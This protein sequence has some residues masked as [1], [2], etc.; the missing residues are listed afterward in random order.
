[1]DD[2]SMSGAK[3]RVWVQIHRLWHRWKQHENNDSAATIAFYALVSLIP[4]LYLGIAVAGVFLGDVVAHGEVEKQ[5]TEVMGPNTAGTITRI[6]G[7]AGA[8][9]RSNVGFLAVIVFALGFAGSH[10]LAKLRLSLNVI[11]GVDAHHPTRPLLGRLFARGLSALLILIFGGLLV[12]WTVIDGL[13]LHFAEAWDSHV[14][15]RWR[16]LQGYDTLSSVVLLV[17]AFALILKV[18]PRKRPLWRYVWPGAVFSGVLVSSLKW[19]LGSYLQQSFLASI[20]GTGLTTLILLFWILLSIKAFLLG[21]EITAMLAE[22][23][24]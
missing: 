5:L 14:I 20:L 13:F 24:E 21:A 18:L 2:E 3:H 9:P 15:D 19:V 6:L 22:S 12:I 16:V 7:Q 8:L 1:M 10:V 4:L 11:N 23:A 17:I